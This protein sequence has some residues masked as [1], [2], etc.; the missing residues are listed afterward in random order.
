MN[1]KELATLKNSYD[2]RKELLEFQ[3]QLKKEPLQVSEYKSLIEQSNLDVKDKASY[4]NHIKTLKEN[5]MIIEDI[6]E[7][8]DDF[9]ARAEKQ[10][11][12][13]I[14]SSVMKQMNAKEFEQLTNKQFALYDDLNGR[15]KVTHYKYKSKHGIMQETGSGISV[16]HQETSDIETI[17]NSQR[18]YN[19]AKE[20]ISKVLAE[21]EVNG[22]KYKNFK[23][24]S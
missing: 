10:G 23:N 14:K 3:E 9:T 20:T 15:D 17:R 12:V 24:E 1:W 13:P 2:R 5:N 16:R 8:F 7:T 22:D 19:K 6:P 4:L 11:K 21:I 18:S